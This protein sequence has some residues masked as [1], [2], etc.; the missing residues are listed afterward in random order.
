MIDFGVQEDF[1]RADTFCD[2]MEGVQDKLRDESWHDMRK[3]VF[4]MDN[5]SYHRSSDALRRLAEREISVLFLP[6]GTPE[7]N[8]CEHF[9]RDLK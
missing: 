3:I 4:W 1:I 9:I 5:A 6:P 7:L 2:F 8:P